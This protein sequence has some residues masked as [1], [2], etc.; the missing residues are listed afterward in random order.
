MKKEVII[1][2]LIGLSMGLIITYGVYRVK[3]SVVNPKTTDLVEATPKVPESS[4]EVL[5]LHSPTDGTIQT[6]TAVT[7]TGTT[8][9]NTYVV[10]FI[11]DKEQITTSD[12]TGNFSIEG[13]LEEGP[14]IISVVVANNDG[15]TFTQ[16]RTIIVTSLLEESAAPPVASSSAQP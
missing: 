5:A 10:I 15:Q 4:P 14:N 11:N 13:T 12:G 7:I 1:A 9:S 3:S 8:Y 2:V 6:D 16:R